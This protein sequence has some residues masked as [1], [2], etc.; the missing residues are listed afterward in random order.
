MRRAQTA[1]KEEERSGLGVAGV[2]RGGD[3]GLGGNK[4]PEHVPAQPGWAGVGLDAEEECRQAGH[5]GLGGHL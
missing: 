4:N 1:G 3:G 5:Q 2:V